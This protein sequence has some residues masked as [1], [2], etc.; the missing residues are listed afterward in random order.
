MRAIPNKLREE[1]AND[2]YYSQCC[3][4]GRN[5][6]GGRIQWHHNLI[7]AGRQVNARFCILPL[8]EWHHDRISKPE[9]KKEVDKIMFSRAT[10]EDLEKYSKAI[11]YK[12]IRERLI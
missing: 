3:L 11:N 2:T 10:D 4:Y 5:E 1:L 8:C 7:F 12:K 6:C 9:I